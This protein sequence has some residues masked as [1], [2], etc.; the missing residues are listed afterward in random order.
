M[1]VCFSYLVVD[2]TI[3]KHCDISTSK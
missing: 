3:K 1:K 2:E